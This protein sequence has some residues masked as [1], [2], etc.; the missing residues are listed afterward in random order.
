MV[1]VNYFGVEKAHVEEFGLPANDAEQP[2][3][4]PVS[5][6]A[7]PSRGSSSPSRLLRVD[8]VCD[9]FEVAWQAGQRPQIEDYLDA[10]PE[11]DRP[12]LLRE[13]LAIE[14]AYRRQQGETLALEEYR[15][16]FP[17]HAELVADVYRAAG[18]W[19]GPSAGEADSSCP[20]VSKGPEPV[21]VEGVEQPSRLGRYRITARLGSGGFGVVYRGYDDELHRDVAIKVPHGRLVSRREDAEAYLTEARSVANLDHPNIVPVFDV[22]SAAEFPCFVVSKLIDGSDLKKRLQGSPFSPAEAAELVATVA[23]ALHYAHRKGLVHRDIKPGNI[24]LDTNGKPYVADFG[25]ALKEEDFGKGARFAGT[26]VYMSPEQAR[27]EGH[28]V[29]GRSDIFSLGVVFYELLTGRRPFRGET[30]EELLEQITSVEPRPPRQMDDEI[31]KELERVCLK[32]LAKRTCER[33]TTAQDFATD[34]RQRQ[35]EKA[36]PGSVH[37]P[38]FIACAQGD[39]KFILPLATLLRASGQTVF[40]NVQDPEYGAD[41]EAQ[42][43]EAIRRS[44]KFLLFWSKLS[45]DSPFLR[46]EWERALATPGCRIVPVM[47]DETPL[48]PALERFHGMEELAPLFRHLRRKKV[49]RRLLWLCWLV[50]AAILAILPVFTV[51]GPSE[52]FALFLSGFVFWLVGLAVPVFIPLW[53]LSRVETYSVYRKVVKLLQFEEGGQA[54]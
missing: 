38:V 26:P 36:S 46:Q 22:G 53:V 43:V 5:A 52:D 33:Y 35:P 6:D 3:G 48:P 15:R 8:E 28:R 39:K 31:P 12:L 24:L 47:L 4:R 27:G 42:V 16:R 30:R 1:K 18:G 13:L 32:A 2:G 17:G 14:L 7:H 45:Q 20:S 25:L 10:A 21:R 11:P 34:L 40:V 29:D 19:V 51:R 49:S 50:L 54:Y 44:K 23:E 37:T 9:R 41:R